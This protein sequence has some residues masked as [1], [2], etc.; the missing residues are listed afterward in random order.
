MYAVLAE[1]GPSEEVII[2]WAEHLVTGPKIT[3]KKAE[4]KRKGKIPEQIGLDN[5]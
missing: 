2:H 4:H 1:R 3:F 5:Y